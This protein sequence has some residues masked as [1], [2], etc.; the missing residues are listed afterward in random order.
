MKLSMT[1]RSLRVAEGVLNYAEGGGDGTPVVLLHGL[2]VDWSSWGEVIE[3]LPDRVHIYA[4]D[5]RGHGQSDWAGAGSGYRIPDFVDDISAF[6]REVSGPGNMIIGISSGALVALGVAARVP[7]LVDAVVAIDPPLVQRDSSF[8]AIAYSEAHGWI[9]W[10]D[11]VGH[12]R[13]SGS[14][15]VARFIAMTPGATV[16]DAEQ[17]LA[18]IAPLDPRATGQ[19]LKSGGTYE[20]YDLGDTLD[21]V[22]CSV[23]MLAG[24]VHLGSLVRDKDL[25]FFQR[26]TPQGHVNRIQGGGHGIIWGDMATAVTD[27]IL[28]W[29]ATLPELA[30]SDWNELTSV[31]TSPF[32]IDPEGGRRES[33]AGIDLQT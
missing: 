19:V 26:H 3:R 29:L 15:A 25:D 7:E 33:Q 12:G 31:R 5:L 30:G 24:E 14:E 6:L 27:E 1:E 11:D 4:P 32:R 8:E 9:H 17:A 21:A 22:S 28:S 13:L 20:D 23:L 18:A 10:V 16:T 2:T